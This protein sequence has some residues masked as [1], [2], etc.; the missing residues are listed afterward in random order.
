[1]P[2]SDEALSTAKF[3][4]AI[5]VT[6]CVAV[7][8]GCS[9]PSGATG[10]NNG[11]DDVCQYE[12]FADYRCENGIVYEKR[13]G[14]IPCSEYSS[15]QEAAQICADR[16]VTE[17][18]TCADGCRTD[19]DNVDQFPSYTPE[20]CAEDRLAQ[21]GD[22]CSEDAACRPSDVGVGP[23]FCEGGVC[24]DPNAPEDAGMNQDAGDTSTIE[25][26]GTGEDTGTAEDTGTEDV[27]EDTRADDTTEDTS[28][29]D[30]EQDTSDAQSQDT[31][32]SSDSSDS[33]DAEDA[34]TD[35]ATD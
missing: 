23:M 11:G 2:V 16:E 9:D 32:D 28:S 3:L 25:D 19:I 26:T 10:T 34:D 29:E 30:A 6:L 21:P 35:D 24:V 22:E 33:N 8:A 31:S 20:L 4:L 1:M 27:T 5:A 15:E 12:C 17:F 18:R 14:P 13:G 7:A